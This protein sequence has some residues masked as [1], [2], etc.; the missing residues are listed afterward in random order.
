VADRLIVS[1]AGWLGPIVVLLLGSTWRVRE[2]RTERVENA[3]GEGRPAVYVFWHGVLLPL[4]YTHRRRNIQVLTSLH[5]DGEIISRILLGLGFGVLRGSSTRGSAR[6]L[7]QMLSRALNGLDVA[8]TPDGPTGPARS[9]KRGV[10]Y[11]TEKSG[12]ALFPVGVAASRVKHLG[13]WDS[14]AIPLPFSRVV[15]VYEG[16]LRWDES[17]PF[18]DKASLLKDALARANEEARRV[19]AGEA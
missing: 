1:L 19:A 14:F 7:M 11:V 2:I 6:G 18:E 9:V 13:S 3:H 4:T 17:A 12:G 10:F 16:P 5:R 15:V 8:I